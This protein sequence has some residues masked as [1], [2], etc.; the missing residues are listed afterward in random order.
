MEPS[1]VYRDI[2]TALLVPDLHASHH[3]VVLRIVDAQGRTNGQS[4]LQ[5]ILGVQIALMGMVG[6][7]SVA[8]IEIV[9]LL[10]V[11]N[12]VH[13][14]AQGIA[15]KPGRHHT[16]VDLDMVN[17]VDGQIRQIHP[18][19]LGVEGDAVDEVAYGIARHA[20]D[21][22]VEVT[23]HAAL[24]SQLHASRAVYQSV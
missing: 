16:F 22:E 11:G 20:I 23:T 6:T 3:I 21:R 2:L 9:H 17:Q 7:E 4:V 14:P 15:A 12:N 19:T 18:G 24:F 13:G 5:H 10:A 8:R 1:A